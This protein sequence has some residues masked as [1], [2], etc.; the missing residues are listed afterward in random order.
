[1][2]TKNHQVPPGLELFSS[3]L[4]EWVATSV[5]LTNCGLGVYFN[6]LNIFPNLAPKKTN[7]IGPEASLV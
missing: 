2:K 7:S 5:R 6:Y 4:K 1:M 3:L